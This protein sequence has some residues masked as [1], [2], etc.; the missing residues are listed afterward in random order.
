MEIARKTWNV[1]DVLEI[2]G[3]ID[4]LTSAALKHSIDQA[5]VDGRRNL[6]LDFTGVSN[7]SSAGL[8]VILQSHKALNQIGGKLKSRYIGIIN[9]EAT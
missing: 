1:F 7:K 5:T 6:V 3:R 8:R 9:L 2:Q 4:G